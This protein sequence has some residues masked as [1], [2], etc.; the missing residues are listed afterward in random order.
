[1]GSA[2]ILKLKGIKKSFGGIQALKGVDFELQEGEVHALLGENG[3]GK[4]TLIKIITGVHQADAGEVLLH[5]ESVTMTT[6]IDARKKG[7]AA[8]YQE[9]SLIESLTVAEN[10]F[11]GNEPTRTALGIYDRRTL[12]Q[13]SQDYLSRFGIE[14]DCR[15]KVSELGMGQKRIIEIV[16][17][18]ALDSRILLLDEPTTGMSKAEIETLFQIMENLKKKNVTMIYISHYLDEVFRIADR[19]TV[20]RDG[21]HVGTYEMGRVTKQELVKSM[22]G[23]AVRAQSRRDRKSFEGKA[24]ILELREFWTDKM[25]RAVSFSLRESEILGITG[26]VGA[27][28]S[29]LAHSI[30]GNAKRRGGQLLIHGQPVHFRNPHGTIPYRLGFVPEDRK[31]QGLF[32]AETVA[33]NMVMAHIGQ[34]EN[35][36]GILNQKKKREICME[37]GQKLRVSPLKPDLPAGSLS[38]GNQ[39][40]V[41]I[42]KWLTS[43][44]EILIMDEPTRGIDVGA[45]SEIYDI[46]CGLADSGTGIL[47]M[48]S[49]FD[50]LA[51]LCDRILVLYKG[52]VAGELT[53][54]EATNERML[55]I[56]LGGVDE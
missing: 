31:A 18:L 42:G 47:I 52:A 26:I 36:F 24:V 20:F 6:P 43:N 35:K 17:A 50:E 41:V 23:K 25:S 8:I 44:P 28:K 22:V 21:A 51:G 32:L 29:E 48:S 5:G 45:K 38:G 4:S 2:V 9:L 12:Y 11:L 40:K 13:N 53:G 34:I 54:E 10:I 39:Q 49:E 55:S 27:G 1:M 15:K 30:F 7:I 16:K 33:D 3:A 56:S 46:I 19:A 14:I 37:T